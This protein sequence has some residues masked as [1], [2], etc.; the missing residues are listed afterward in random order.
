MSSF[1]QNVKVSSALDYA[2]GTA[3]RTGTILD[4][5]G[6][7][8][9]ICIV[10][11]ATVAAG[12]TTAFH[13]QQ[14]TAVA[15]GSAANINGTQ[16]FIDGSD[17]NDV[18]IIDVPQPAERYVRLYVNK[19]GSNACAESAVYIQYG[20]GYAPVTNAVADSVY[21]QEAAQRAAEGNS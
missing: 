9:V 2:T 7:E 21:V 13:M 15:M 10:K 11:L 14:D 18:I 19:D 6:Y 17:D 1:L 5:K 12:G 20:P 8:G 3:D 4:M 16:Q